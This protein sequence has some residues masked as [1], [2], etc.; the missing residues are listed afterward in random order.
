M[1]LMKFREPNQV[2]W[3]GSRPGH[4]GTQVYGYNAQNGVGNAIV[5]VV[6][7]DSTLFITYMFSTSR[8]GVA[9]ACDGGLQIYTD[10]FV[11]WRVLMPHLYDLAGHQLYC[12]SLDQ[13]IEVPTGYSIRVISSNAALD[14]AGGIWGWIE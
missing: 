13:P 3:V 4:D 7:A 8:V 12:V 11:F 1:A 6:P 9:A 14:V 5:Y 10:G 2:R